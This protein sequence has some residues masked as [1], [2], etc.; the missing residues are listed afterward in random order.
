[1]ANPERESMPEND[2]EPRLEREATE[3]E[4]AGHRELVATSAPTAYG[5]PITGLS[6][7]DDD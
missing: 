4:Q 5:V 6:E 1:M 3:A 2:E 7:P